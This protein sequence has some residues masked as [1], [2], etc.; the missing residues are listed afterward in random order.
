MTTPSELE[1]PPTFWKRWF[2]Q[3]VDPKAGM[4]THEVLKR[5]AFGVVMC[6]A[7]ICYDKYFGSSSFLGIWLAVV[8]L[9]SP[10]LVLRRNWW[11][12]AGA[13]M[14]GLSLALW[15]LQANG[16]QNV[17][18]LGTWYG[19]LAGLGSRNLLA[20][21]VGIFLGSLGAW[22]G[23][24]VLYR[25]INDM[26]RSTK[27]GMDILIENSTPIIFICWCMPIYLCSGI[28]V[29]LGVKLSK[30]KGSAEKPG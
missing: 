14:F 8:L 15:S 25:Y 22:L 9:F 19:L 17:L 24:N 13:M 6:E 21:I 30:W 1:N 26:L 16:A 23:E 4:F 12:G 18:I 5:V 11:L 29:W 2:G 27:I 20:S 10:E 3:Q 28:A 7:T